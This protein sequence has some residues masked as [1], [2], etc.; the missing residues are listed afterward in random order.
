MQAPICHPQVDRADPDPKRKQ[1][2]AGHPPML[3]IGQFSDQEIA[4]A[5]STLTVMVDVAHAAHGGRLAGISARVVRRMCR[6]CDGSRA[7]SG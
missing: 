2:P 1:L 5:T 6:E 7:A 4:W 3:P